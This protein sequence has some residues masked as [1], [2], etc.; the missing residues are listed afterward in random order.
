[1]IDKMIVDADI[2]IKLG[3]SAKYQYLHDILPLAANEILMHTHAYGEVMMPPSAVNQLKALINEGKITLV[4]ESNLGSADRAVYDATFRN[5]EKV[6]IDPR[7]SNKNRGEACSLAYA[8]A[9]GIPV[10]ATDERN[11]QPMIDNQLN[12]GIDDIICLRIIDIIKKA[13]EGE[14]DIPRKACK[15]LWV[16]SGKSKDAF[17]RE[18]WPILHAHGRIR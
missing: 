10:F 15:A 9:A 12:T 1:M 3:G 4:N 16:I 7:R 17:D 8:K 11:L 6:M 18:L 14:I 13:Q 5:L 2:C